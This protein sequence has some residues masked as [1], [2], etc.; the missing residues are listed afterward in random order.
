L[1]AN[2][3]LAT[4]DWRLRNCTARAHTRGS[5]A[6]VSLLQKVGDKK[7]CPLPPAGQLAATLA[8]L[9]FGPCSFGAAGPNLQRAIKEQQKER[10]REK[11]KL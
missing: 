7:C 8:G 1:A 3:Q 9:P 4:G 6:S 11:Q 10:E 5:Q 2:W